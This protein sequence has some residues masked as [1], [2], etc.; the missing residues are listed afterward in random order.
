MPVSAQSVRREAQAAAV[1]YPCLM[2]KPGCLSQNQ[3]MPKNRRMDG[4]GWGW[5]EN[6]KRDSRGGEGIYRSLVQD[7]CV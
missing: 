2:Q 1:V 4:R 6:D 7:R 5:R 3:S